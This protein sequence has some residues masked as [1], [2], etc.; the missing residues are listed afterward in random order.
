MRHR[1]AP[2]GLFAAVCCLAGVAHAQGIDCSR[3]RSPTEKAICASPA[4][5]SLD[6]QVAVAYADALARQPDQ[7]DAMRTDLLRWLRQ[8]D[9][10][11]NVPAAAMERCLAGQLTARLAALAPPAAPPIAARCGGPAAGHAGRAGRAGRHPGPGGPPA[12]DTPPAPL[13]TLDAASL[14]AAPKRTR[15]CT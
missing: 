4:L 14:P 1:L 8:R 5:L 15:C 3:A 10:T 12:G 13:A 7:R 2:A 6:H 11:C 9:A